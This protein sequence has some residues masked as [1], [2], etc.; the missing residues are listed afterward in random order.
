[1]GVIEDRAGIQRRLFRLAVADPAPL[2]VTGAAS[3]LG[4]CAT[5]AQMIVAA[6]LVVSGFEDG[7]ADRGP[8][9]LAFAIAVAVRVAASAAGEWAAQVTATRAKA[10]LR[11]DMVHGLVARGP[12]RSAGEHTG[13]LITMA[14]DGVE[15]LDAFYRRFL[16]QAM[17]TAIV[18]PV[19]LI[20][21]SVLDPLSGVILGITGP[22]IPLFMWLLG[23]LAERRAHEQWRA[24]GLLGARFL[25][26]L[27]GLP[28]LAL[29]NRQQ[30]A[31]RSLDMASERLR[32]RTMGVL[33]VAFLSG[34]VLELAASVSTAL[35]AAGVGVRLIEGVLTFLPGLTVLLLAPEFYLPFRQLGARHHA[36]M[37]GAAVAARIFEFVD[38]PATPAQELSVPDGSAKTGGLKVEGLTVRYPGAE[39]PALQ[40][41]SLTLEPGTLTAIVGPSGAGKS[42]LLGVLL[43]F[44][45]AGRGEVRFAGRALQE[46]SAEEWRRLIAYVPQRPRF[47]HGTIL[48]NL[49]LACPEAV[50]AE[51]EAAARHAQ[52]H[53]FIAALPDAYDTII[54]DSAS[55]LSGGE[56]QRLALARALLK[57]APIL[58]LDEPTSSLDRTSEALVVGALDRLRL[59]RI[60]LVAAHRLAT[61]QGADQVLVLDEGRIV[62]RGSHEELMGRGRTYAHL[63][64][65]DHQEVA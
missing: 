42:T 47:M 4:A 3:L 18:P 27:Q 55:S 2:A 63:V 21:V 14:M 11:M 8:L 65:V 16:P 10:R 9:F 25:D 13:E 20:A 34:F 62:E 53:A 15:K 37:E 48:D 19:I 52:A 39:R 23:V 30:D 17:A 24:L 35:V 6:R 57:P 60:V 45:E 51:V 43:R 50:L 49:R 36:G 12:R 33:R 32:T 56:R 31:A 44:V 54:D 1:V 26:T 59:D 46:M 40:E 7:A 61:V 58:L 22:L 41:V 28:T 29:F 5:V 38:T 64:D